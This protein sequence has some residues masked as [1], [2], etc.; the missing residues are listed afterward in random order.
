MQIWEAIL[1]EKIDLLELLAYVAYAADPRPAPNARMPGP[2]RSNG[3]TTIKPASLLNDVLGHHVDTGVEDLDL[4]LRYGAYAQGAEALRGVE[5][6][7]DSF[8]R[9]KKH[10]YSSIIHKRLCAA[11]PQTPVWRSRVVCAFRC[12]VAWQRFKAASRPANDPG[13]AEAR[14]RRVT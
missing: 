12:I 6:N 11:R 3:N 4:R 1:A 8:F 10:L 7:V 13:V 5:R 9:F 2:G 14:L